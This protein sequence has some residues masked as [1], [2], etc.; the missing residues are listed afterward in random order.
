MVRSFQDA[1]YVHWYRGL[2]SNVFHG[3]ARSK[4]RQSFLFRRRE[5]ERH[6][7]ITRAKK[8]KKEHGGRGAIQEE[9][10]IDHRTDRRKVPIPAI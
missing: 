8:H 5:Q 9:T 6:L 3:P 10:A 4:A 1:A 7:T 2:P